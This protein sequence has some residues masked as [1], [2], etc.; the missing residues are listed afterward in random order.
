[1]DPAKFHAIEQRQRT[2]QAWMPLTDLC[3]GFGQNRDDP[4]YLAALTLFGTLTGL[5]P[6]SLGADEIAARD[7]GIS[8][9][10]ALAL[11][12]VASL[13]LGFTPPVPEPGT[14]ATL[15]LGVA[16]LAAL[17]RRRRRQGRC[18]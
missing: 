5:D 17:T 13:Q 8:S 18:V 16:A 15:A 10:D 11:Q 6:F 7:L 2:K 12:R 14:W 1:L 4:S 3:R 9:V